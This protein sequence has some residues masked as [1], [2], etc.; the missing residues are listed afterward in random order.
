M[1]LALIIC[2]Q[3]R[4]TQVT[5]EPFFNEPFVGVCVC[6]GCYLASV[7]IMCVAG[8]RVRVRN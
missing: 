8:E 1:R 7:P 3:E 5:T 4:R 6:V 2:L